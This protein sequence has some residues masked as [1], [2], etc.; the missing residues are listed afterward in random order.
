MQP[1]LKTV[2][3]HHWIDGV[4]VTASGRNETEALKNLLEK[5]KSM[6]NNGKA[7]P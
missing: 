2:Y 7:K 3:A 4:K 1:K 6:K 5:L